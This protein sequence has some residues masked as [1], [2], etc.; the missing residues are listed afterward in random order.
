[1]NSKNIDKL[2]WATVFFIG[3]LIIG[4]A[5]LFGWGFVELIRWITTK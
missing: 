1:M 5:V 3:F 2:A 4:A